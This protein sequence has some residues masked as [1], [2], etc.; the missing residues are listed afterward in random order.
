MTLFADTGLRNTTDQWHALDATTGM[1]V[2]DLPSRFGRPWQGTG[3][4][5]IDHRFALADQPHPVVLDNRVQIAARNDRDV[6]PRA[7]GLDQLSQAVGRPRGRITVSHDDA[8]AVA[9][10]GRVAMVEVVEH[11]GQRGPTPKTLRG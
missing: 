4:G 10:R 11:W 6:A 3:F 8:W 2:F 1:A 7:V 5:P 9:M